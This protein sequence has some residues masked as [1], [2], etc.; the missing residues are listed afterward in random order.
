MTL[1]RHRVARVKDRIASRL[2]E[3]V[4]TLKEGL[5]VATGSVI[6]LVLLFLACAGSQR[7]APGPNEALFEE[8]RQHFAAGRWREASHTL[9]AF[10]RDCSSSDDRCG[11]ALLMQGSAEAAQ[12][13]VARA[14]LLTRTAQVGVGSSAAIQGSASTQLSR[15]KER[16]DAW[17]QGGPAE[18]PLEIV[19]DSEGETWPSTL[20]LT[21]DAR[22][23]SLPAR[24]P[25]A[26]LTLF[27]G[28][29]PSGAHVVEVSASWSAP[30]A[31]KGSVT[32]L[33]QL[34]PARG[35]GLRVRQRD[36][37]FP[38]LDVEEVTL[39]R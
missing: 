12:G 24:G 34:R 2:K 5:R 8:G 14:I 30:P 15:L 23:I 27:A 25:G 10:G 28:L 9:E 31:M 33:I 16:A 13:N 18:S 20:A 7:A 36:A 1:S 37:R 22:P 29:A 26:S 32:R 6:G 39:Q 38:Q 35:V 17:W 4:P 3:E 21:I 19:F 11:E